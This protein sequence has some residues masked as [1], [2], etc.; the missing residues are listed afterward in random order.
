VG[1]RLRLVEAGVFTPD[2]RAALPDR[3]AHIHSRV[4]ELLVRLSPGQLAVEDIFHAV[5]TRTALVLGH[6]R[7]V[8]L[9][10]GAQAG[11]PISAFPPATVKLQVTGNGRAE[12]SQ[13]ALMVAHHLGLRTDA[14]PGDAMDALAV[15][16]CAAHQQNTLAPR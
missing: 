11:L 13:V 4:A 2:R 6:V 3:L 7:G 8:V 16:I 10:A 1:Q 12:K 14:P 9:L 5:N 15:A